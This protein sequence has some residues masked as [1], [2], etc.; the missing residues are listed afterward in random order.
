MKKLLITLFW[1][2]IATLLHS[3]NSV[4]EMEKCAEKGIL[5]DINLNGGI[6]IRP[7]L[8]D[9]ISNWDLTNSDFG[10][11]YEFKSSN[12]DFKNAKL[13]ESSLYLKSAGVNSLSQSIADS[14]QAFSLCKNG[15]HSL[16]VTSPRKAP[17]RV[18]KG[19]KIAQYLHPFIT[20]SGD[21]IYYS[22]NSGNQID[23]FDIFLINKMEDGWSSPIRLNGGVNTPYNQL[24]PTFYDDTLFYS[25]DEG[26]GL[27]LYTSA[28][29]DQFKTNQKMNSPFNS[30]D[31]D[32]LVHKKNNQLYY[33][34]SNREN[35]ADSPFKVTRENA[36]VKE[37]M[38]ITG[39]LACSGNR[40]SNIPISLEKILGTAIDNDI[41]DAEGNFILR[42][43]KQIK[44]YKLKLDKNDERLEECAVLYLTDNE[45]NVIQKILVNE[46][47]EFIFEIIDPDEI[48]D[49]RFKSIEDE[50]LL[51]VEIDGQIYENTPGDIGKGEP[52]KI[53]SKDGEMIALAYTS[54]DGTF[55]F[56]DLSPDSK[57]NLKFDEN[58]KQ[59][60]L[61]IIKD[62]LAVP[63]PIKNN[64]AIYE[65]IEEK[66]ALEIIDDRGKNITIAKDEFF[67]LQNIF[68]EN[69]SSELSQIAKFQLARF[70][71]L[72]FN[73]DEIS[74]ELIS[75]TDSKGEKLY[76]FN[77]SEKRSKKAQE[78]LF[79]LGVSKDKVT[80]I[81]KGENEIL[82]KCTD[83]INC[84][85]EEHAI[86]RRTEIKIVVK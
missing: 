82:N 41:T 64:E 43:D 6:L 40:I 67:N 50:S 37:K 66:N 74:V 81:G 59:L 29:T 63:I 61:D 19:T 24:F 30:G 12:I 73:N 65:R 32:F 83:G 77:L 39:Y 10:I 75:H 16:Y 23:N 78:Y 51:Q 70:S 72:L 45:G 1:S 17:V 49:L 8:H 46:E 18:L 28:K 48:K 68:Y 2:S 15:V 76:N 38:L 3:Q 20:D 79:S 27:D 14:S 60:K 13:T 54:P 33:I 22:S 84:A 34:T 62:G 25:S 58:S 11:A 44:K 26:N 55:K 80:A 53:L 21:Q 69:N 47:N 7:G 71:K 52:V 56:S 5:T 42:A 36:A 85:E 86:N 4:L 31:D 57:Y 35:S 9:Y